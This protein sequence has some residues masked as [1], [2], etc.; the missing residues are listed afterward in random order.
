MQRAD[1]SETPPPSPGPLPAAVCVLGLGLIG[2]SVLRAAGKHTPTFG[3][4]P[5]PETRRAAVQDGYDVADTV[6]D[7]LRRAE[8]QDALAVLAAPVT[9]FPE[10]LRTVNRVAPR[11]RLTDVGSIKAAVQDQVDDLAPQA[12]FVGSHPMAGTARSGWSAGDP[13]LFQGAVW[14]TSLIAD[15]LVDDWATVAGLALTLGSRVVPLDP[16]AHDA[17]VARISHLP[18]VLALVLAAVG[19]DSGAAAMSLAASSFADGTRV[20]GTRPQLIRAMCEGNRPALV[21]A[22]DEALGLLGVARASLASTGS[23]SKLATMGHDAR[24]RFE[25][26]GADLEPMEL[27]GDDLIEQLL[28]VGSSGGHVSGVRRDRDGWR[29]QA[30]YPGAIE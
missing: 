29:I 9:A 4:S 3:W 13:N 26:R 17:A 2:G 28:A 24:R 7:A 6:E 23:L 1:D 21:D 5:S 16:G 15:S 11:I 14:V 12:R 19:A 25:Q 10:L 27:S 30:W 8:A 22:L 18:H 20:A